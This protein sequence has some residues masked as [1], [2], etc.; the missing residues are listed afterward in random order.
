VRSAA[1][2]LLW[3]FS[4][5]PAPSSR[6]TPPLCPSPS[7]HLVPAT[8]SGDDVPAEDLALH[9][10]QAAYPDVGLLKRALAGQHAGSVLFDLDDDAGHVLVQLPGERGGKEGRRGERRREEDSM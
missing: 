7:S 8:I 5:P 4:L 3:P 6:L 9:V 10:G 1:G 2:P